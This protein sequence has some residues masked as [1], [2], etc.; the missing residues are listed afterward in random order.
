MIRKPSDWL[1]LSEVNGLNLQ[2]TENWY[3]NNGIKNKENM[4]KIRK[5]HL[6]IHQR[7]KRLLKLFF[8][9]FDYNIFQILYSFFVI[10]LLNF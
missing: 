6:Q 3:L 10:F 2:G 7:L 9:K 8:I 1:H 5:H 4:K